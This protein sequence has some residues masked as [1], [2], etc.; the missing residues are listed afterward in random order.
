MEKTEINII[1]KAVDKFSKTFWNVKKGV[2]GLN[3]S[4][5]KNQA[6]FQKMAWFWSLA[7]AGLWLWIKNLTDSAS[8]LVEINQKFGVVYSEMQWK[9]DKTA[10][11]LADWYGL[12]QSKARGYLADIGDLV[13]GLWYTQEAWLDFSK[14]VVSLWTDL[15]SFSNVAGWSE[16]AIDR[17][18]KWLLGEHENLKALWVQIDEN[19][20][21]ERLLAMWKSKLTWLALKQAKV[22]AR[23]QM[24]MEQSKNAIWDF[25]R[26]KDSLANKTRIMQ[27]KIQ[28]LK[29]TMWQAF[30][31]IILKI[32]NAIIPLVESFANWASKNETLVKWLGLWAIWLAGFLAVAGTI[33][34]ILPTIIWGISALWTA[35]AILTG[36]IWLVVG[37]IWLFAIAYK[38]D[39]MWFRGF[40]DETAKKVKVIF[41]KIVE[42]VMSL[43]TGISKWV[44]R[45][46]EPFM[47]VVNFLKPFVIEF[48]WTLMTFFKES[49]ENIVTVLSGAWDLIKWIVQVA[50][51]IIWWVIEVFLNLITWNWSGAW[52][53]IKNMFAGIWEWIKNILSWVL[54]IMW[55]AISQFGSTIKALFSGMW[56]AV[57]TIISSTLTAI[58]N[59]ISSIF[60]WISSAVSGIVSG[61]YNAVVGKFT[62]M[63]DKVRWIYNTVKSWL[64]KIFWAESKAKQ[65][66]RRVQNI[67]YQNAQPVYWTGAVVGARAK[68]WDIEWWRTYLVWERGPELFTPATSWSITPNNQ[69]QWSKEIK[70]SFWDVHINNWTDEK[71]FFRKIK[72]TM[73]EV[74]RQSAQWY[75]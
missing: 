18:K 32:T 68:G 42:D 47:E 63:L 65:S 69:L 55:G 13:S 21:K 51:S 7:F 64:W 58:A 46:K 37:A 8:D 41:D 50:T 9:A 25:A 17:L 28:D 27:A 31:P 2:G 75:S 30:Y 1:V 35:F 49:F 29:D 26:S 73:I 44:N 38:K 70:V 11:S 33:W 59:I 16:E 53:G 54:K 56:T 15:A 36:P 52:T 22:E 60:S 40:V 39:F 62:G 72:N 34:L 57:K 45:I 61:I 23:L 24:V 43:W 48:L 14:S 19:M 3:K 12:A 74:Q 67:A 10:K 5:Q 20:V 6:N 4:L 66:Q 71:S